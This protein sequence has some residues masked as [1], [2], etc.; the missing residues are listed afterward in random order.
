MDYEWVPL[1]LANAARAGPQVS[2]QG[3]SG[4]ALLHDPLQHLPDPAG[5]VDTGVC[6]A[7]VPQQLYVCSAETH[8]T[9]CTSYIFSYSVHGSECLQESPV[10]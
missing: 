3:V 1:S 10:K 9:A 4:G 6:R 7:P 8:F 2:A 5:H